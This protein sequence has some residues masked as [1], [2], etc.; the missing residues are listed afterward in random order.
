MKA[1]LIQK[2]IRDTR[3]E[4]IGLKAETMILELAVKRART[5]YSV[6]M[7]HSDQGRDFT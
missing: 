5:I 6:L 2:K 7:V 1:S 3:Q 4:D